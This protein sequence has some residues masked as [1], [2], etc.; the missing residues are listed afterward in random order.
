MEKADKETGLN[1]MEVI[2]GISPRGIY[3]FKGKSK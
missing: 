3:I 2:S 1:E